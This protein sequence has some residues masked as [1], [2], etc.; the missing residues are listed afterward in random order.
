MAD[1][2]IQCPARANLVVLTLGGVCDELVVN[3]KEFFDKNEC[4]KV[5][6][7]TSLSSPSSD[8]EQRSRDQLSRSM[9]FEM[10]IL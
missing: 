10:K 5:G 4:L 9:F 1:L 3:V 7:L 8:Q 6:L 2:P